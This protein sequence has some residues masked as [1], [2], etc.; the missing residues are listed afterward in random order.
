MKQF[1]ILGGFG[2]FHDI[3]LKKKKSILII[4]YLCEIWFDTI[5]FT[6][7]QIIIIDF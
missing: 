3:N 1:A 2:L 7:I 6:T 5:F 4:V